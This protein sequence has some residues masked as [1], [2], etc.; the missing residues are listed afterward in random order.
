MRKTIRIVTLALFVILPTVGF[1]QQKALKFGHINRQEIL[2]LMP[3]RDSASVKLNKYGLELEETLVAMNGELNKKIEKYNKTLKNLLQL[4][5][6]GIDIKEVKEE[7]ANIKRE[8]EFLDETLLSLTNESFGDK[9]ISNLVTKVQLLISD[10]ERIFKE[11]PVH[12]KKKLIRLFVEKIEFDPATETINFY[13]R[14][15]PG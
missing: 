13:V 1:A 10:F 9:D 11:S 3:E 15:F 5:G 14:T 6:D 4:V 8:R 7:M 2:A 12:I